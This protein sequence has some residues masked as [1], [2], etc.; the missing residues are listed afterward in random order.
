VR[1]GEAQGVPTPMN[2]AIAALIKGLERSWQQ[3]R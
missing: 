2:R 1:F 3:P